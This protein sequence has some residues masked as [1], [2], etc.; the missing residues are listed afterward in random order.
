MPSLWCTCRTACRSSP[1][2]KG[3]GG[4]SPRPP[5]PL[6]PL[7]R[8]PPGEGAGGLGAGYPSICFKNMIYYS[9][10]Y[11]FTYK[12]GQKKLNINKSIYN[13][14]QDMY[15][16]WPSTYFLTHSSILTTHLFIQAIAKWAF[17]SI[18]IQSSLF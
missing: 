15:F 12:N 13:I 10:Y 5:A 8:P 17:P 2:G 9:I 4:G 7:P 6:L 14:G 1:S 16:I 18:R 3:T 11:I